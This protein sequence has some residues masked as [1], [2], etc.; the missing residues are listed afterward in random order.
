MTVLLRV[1]LA[2]REMDRVLSTLQ[3]TNDTYP[4]ARSELHDAVQAWLAEGDS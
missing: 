1:C 2:A 3:P 4:A